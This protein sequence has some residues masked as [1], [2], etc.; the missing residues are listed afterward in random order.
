MFVLKRNIV[1]GVSL[2]LIALLSDVGKFSFHFPF[3][4]FRLDFFS[5]CQLLDG[6]G[7]IL[8]RLLP[9]EAVS[10]ISFQVFVGMKSVDVLLP[11]P[12]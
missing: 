5:C 3:Q 8:M 10:G 2:V 12:S 9:F 11:W 6:A 7:V 4:N 1:G